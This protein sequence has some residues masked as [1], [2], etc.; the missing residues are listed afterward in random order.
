[1][2]YRWTDEGPAF[3][4]PTPFAVENRMLVWRGWLLLGLALAMAAVTAYLHG[5]EPVTQAVALEDRPEPASAWPL[6]LLAFGMAVSAVLDLVRAA[7]QQTLRLQRGQPA[8]LTQEV[9]HEATGVGAGAPALMQAL[10]KGER[11]PGVLGGP[12]QR[13]LRRLGPVHAAPRPLQVFLA[14]RVAHLMLS[15]GLLVVLAVG[16]VLL[17]NK[18]AALAVLAIVVS[19]LGAAFVARQVV[20]TAEP[21]FGHWVLLATL[22]LAAVALPPLFLFGAKLTAAAPFLNQFQLP[23]ALGVALLSGLLFEAFGL[24]AARAQLPRERPYQLEREENRVAFGND[25]RTLLQE[26]ERELYRRWT[27][28]VPNR[29]YA[30]QPPFVDRAAVAGECKALVL[31]ESQPMVHTMSVAAPP[32]RKLPEHPDPDRPPP[33]PPPPSLNPPPGVGWLRLLAVCGLVW[34]L[35]GALLWLWLAYTR[36]KNPAAPW[37]PAALGLAFLGGAGYALRIGHLLWS[38]IELQSTLTWI[39]L[40]GT[41]VRTAAA[42][43]PPVPEKVGAQRGDKPV[44]V[45]SLTVLSA[46]AQLRSVFYAAVPGRVQGMRTLLDWQIDGKAAAGWAT[47]VDAFAR[48]GDTLAAAASAAGAAAGRAG[49]SPAAGAAAPRPAARAPEAE[50][51]M[52]SRRSA[53]FCSACGTPVLAAARFCQ[54]CGNAL[55]D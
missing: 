10:L 16:A 2:A 25:P 41:F 14:A 17:M 3:E 42:A 53:R 27:E 50:P 32:K 55:S 29:R 37:W 20:L 54:H 33:P 47:F 12:Y 5:Q 52:A 34:A 22:L 28:G 45:D 13:L 43:P 46:V 40:K 26:V 7:R 48:G 21:P 9:P 30:W 31:E 49:N 38:R 36:M 11:P 51:A 39:E 35:V 23:L 8:S 24:L 18:G 4:F 15:A 19:V 44:R 1:M 6:Y